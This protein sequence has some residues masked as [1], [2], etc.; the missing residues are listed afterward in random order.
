MDWKEKQDFE[1]AEEIL[2]RGLAVPQV[3]D[4]DHI[5]ERLVNLYQESDSPEE[6]KKWLDYQSPPAAKISKVKYVIPSKKRRKKKK[7]K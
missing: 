5:I 6:A 1:K 2:K 7:K 3:E 4:R